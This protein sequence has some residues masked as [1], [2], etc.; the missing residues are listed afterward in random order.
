M[1]FIAL[2]YAGATLA[3]YEYDQIHMMQLQTYLTTHKL[4]TLWSNIH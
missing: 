2:V 4:Y 3:P 1:C